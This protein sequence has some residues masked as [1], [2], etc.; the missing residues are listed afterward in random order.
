VNKNE[1]ISLLE[2]L[3]REEILHTLFIMMKIDSSL[4]TQLDEWVQFILFTNEKYEKK[5]LNLISKET[6]SWVRK[7]L[8]DEAMLDIFT[9]S[10]NDQAKID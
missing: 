9:K 3:L 6:P 10:I 1:L 5:M 8:S 7:E 4:I 2:T